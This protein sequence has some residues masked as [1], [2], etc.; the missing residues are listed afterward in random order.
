MV[1]NVKHEGAL[2]DRSISQDDVSPEG[3]RRGEG[4][5]LKLSFV[6]EGHGEVVLTIYK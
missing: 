3:S 6:P 2:G 4:A 5:C 1:E